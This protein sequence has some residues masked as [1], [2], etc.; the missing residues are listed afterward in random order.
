[1]LQIRNPKEAGWRRGFARRT[2][3]ELRRRATELDK[4]IQAE[5]G[6]GHTIDLFMEHVE[7]FDRLRRRA[8]PL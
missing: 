3:Q 7:R 1:M 6:L 2:N 5:D 8:G 4:R